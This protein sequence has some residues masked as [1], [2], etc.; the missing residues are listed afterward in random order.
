MQAVSASVLSLSD[1]SSCIITG[2]PFEFVTPVFRRISEQSHQNSDARWVQFFN[3]PILSH[4]R[5][6][7]VDVF[8]A[9]DVTNRQP[10]Q[11]DV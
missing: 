6:G 11:I 7:K 5:L 2:L 10:T 1:T 3:H 8:V 9:R 4:L